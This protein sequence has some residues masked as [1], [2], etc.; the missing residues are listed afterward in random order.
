[1]HAPQAT[2]ERSRL[3][4]PPSKK[5]TFPNREVAFFVNPLTEVRTLRR[6]EASP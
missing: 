5:A 1:M 3:V 4:S 2:L 6:N